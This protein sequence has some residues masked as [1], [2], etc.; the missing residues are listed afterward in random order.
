ME[1]SP[2]LSEIPKDFHL[3]QGE[4]LVHLE[5]VPARQRNTKPSSLRELYRLTD[6]TQ[7]SEV[8]LN[9]PTVAALG[10]ENEVTSE[11]QDLYNV[12]FGRDSLRV[13][14]DLIDY[15]PKLARSTITKLAETQ[16]TAYVTAQEQEPGKIPHEIRDE[17]DPIAHRL[18]KERGWA[19]PY[20]GSIDATPEFIRTLAAYVNNHQ[21]NQAFLFEA[22][23]DGD[24]EPRAIHEALTDA[25]NWLRRRLDDSQ[26]SFVEYQS[27]IPGGIENQV[28]KDSPDA[29]H[30]ADGSIANH[31][32]GIAALEVQT[33][34][35]DALRD[36]A[37]LYEIVLQRPAEAQ[38]LRERAD[39]LARNILQKFWTDDKGGY[40]V[41]GLDYDD[42]GLSRQMKVRT[43]NMGH[44]LNSRLIDG[45]DPERTHKRAAILRQLQSPE[46]LTT[47]GIRTLASDEV[48]Y[49]A[50]AYH[51]G[52]VW[53][54]DTH[55]IAKGARRHA[56]EP[57]FSA[58]ADL[59]DK[60]IIEV[61]NLIGGFPEYVRGGEHI[62]INTHIIDVNDAALG[63]INRVEQPPQEVQAW[64]VAAILVSKRLLGYKLLGQ[65]N[66]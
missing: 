52:S 28:W 16:G 46:L 51:N 65:Q 41:L 11:H 21:E 43:S 57:Q 13:A 44:V 56:Q 59:L 4:T 25:V 63:K 50:G 31:S 38:E 7:A 8:G 3:L 48:R 12:T 60:K 34:S 47:S 55:H 19:W 14:L 45:D 54:W 10:Y 6:A 58:F 36:A 42:D 5:H 66:R 22:Y 61:A 15:Y 1:Q 18:T 17:N 32:D 40:F 29:Y 26:M 62:A 49:R 23:T 37:D 9:G 35:Y 24:G 64:S 20:Y 53:I 30:H 33:V 27:T 39:I 2:E